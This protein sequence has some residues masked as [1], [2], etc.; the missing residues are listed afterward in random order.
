ML[1]NQELAVGVFNKGPKKKK[2]KKENALLLSTPQIIYIC[3]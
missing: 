2:N 3:I 1:D